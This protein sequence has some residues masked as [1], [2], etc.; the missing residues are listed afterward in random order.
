MRRA[1]LIFFRA[2]LGY[3]SPSMG[4]R[5]RISDIWQSPEYERGDRR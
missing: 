5:V 3:P 1:L 2:L 4:R